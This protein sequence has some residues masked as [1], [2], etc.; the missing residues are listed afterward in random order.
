M[1]GV[2]GGYRLA[3]CAADRWLPTCV[4][5]Q[6]A[7][8]YAHGIPLLLQGPVVPALDRREAKA[9]GLACHRVMPGAFGECRNCGVELALLGW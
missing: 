8:Q 6:L 4:G 5:A 7:A 9:R 2:L 3:Y 1:R